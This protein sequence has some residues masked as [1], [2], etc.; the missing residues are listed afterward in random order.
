[1]E[2][3]PIAVIAPPVDTAGSLKADKIILSAIEKVR[4]DLP[5]GLSIGTSGIIP[6]ARDEMKSVGTYTIA[7]SLIALLLVFLALVWNFKSFLIPFLALIPI[8]I[9]I[10]WAMGFYAV[11]LGQLNIM[12]AMIMLV[13]IGLG[14]DFAIHMVTRFYEEINAEKSLNEALYLSVIETGKGIYTSG[15][16]TAMAFFA[17]MV[18]ETKGISEFG[19]CAGSGVIRVS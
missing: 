17:L 18:S 13:L 9:G 8:V 6:I 5:Q 12:T 7:L 14:I 16:T 2:I 1:M 4:P 10:F 19:F 3:I 15:I 11:A